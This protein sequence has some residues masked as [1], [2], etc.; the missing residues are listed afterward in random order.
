MGKKNGIG[1]VNFIKCYYRINFLA[2]GIQNIDSLLNNTI[3]PNV[4]LQRSVDPQQLS[5]SLKNTFLTNSKNIQVVRQQQS[6]SQQYSPVSNFQISPNA[7]TSPSNFQQQQQQQ[8]NGGPNW[9]NLRL[10][11]QQQNE[12]IANAQLNVSF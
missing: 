5:P 4:A 3:A 7:S 2:L 11:Q 12:L 6:Q 9:A 10:T 8:T 1:Y